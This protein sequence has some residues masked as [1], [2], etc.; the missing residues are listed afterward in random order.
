MSEASLKNEIAVVDYGA[1]NLLSV[2]NALK[3]LGCAS[4]DQ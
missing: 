3:F 2:T 4:S 1:S